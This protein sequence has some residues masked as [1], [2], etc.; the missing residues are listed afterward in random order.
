ML[1]P[2]PQRD[3][4]RGLARAGRG[5]A[6]GAGE[7]PAHGRGLWRQGIA[8]GPARRGVGRG[9]ARHRPAREAALRPRRRL[10]DHRPPPRLR[11]RLGSGIRRRRPPA[12]RGTLDD[13]QRGLLHRPVATRA[14]AGPLPRRQRVLDPGGVPARAPGPDEH[15]VQHRFPRLWWPSGRLR[16]RG[17]PRRGG[18]PPRARRAGRAAYQFLWRRPPQ[19]HALRP[20]PHR[21]RDLAAD[22]RAGAHQRLCAAPH[23]SGPLQRD[24]PGAQEGPGPHAGE[25]RH[26]LQPAAPEPGRGPGARLHRRIGAREPRRHRDGP[27]PEHQGGA[28]GGAGTGPAAGARALFGHRHEQGRQ[29]LG[30]RRLH[31]Q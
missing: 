5:S 17:D 27:G 9:G 10:H 11:V 6:P 22:G 18:T 1:H 8:V 29:H 25:V 15:P 19:R 13:R 14:D 31:R 16:H 3:A 4:A 23:R 28:S 7:L 20:D 26:L 24:Q 2:T 30:H 12:G 21:Q